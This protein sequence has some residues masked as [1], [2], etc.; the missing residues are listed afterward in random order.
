MPSLQDIANQVNNTLTQINTNTA[1]C[2]T[3]EALIKG[4]TADLNSKLATLISQ[5]QVDFANLSAGLAKVID[6]RRCRTMART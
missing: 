3:T 2:A 6:E 4:D 5:E 1:N